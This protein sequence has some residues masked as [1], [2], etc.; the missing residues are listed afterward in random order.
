VLS[1]CCRDTTDTDWNCRRFRWVACQLDYLCELPRDKDRRQALKSL[2]PTLNATYERILGRIETKGSGVQQLVQRCLSFLAVAD[3][4]PTSRELCDAVS[5]DEDMVYLDNDALVDEESIL[6]HCSSL[7]RCRE[8]ELDDTGESERYIE[9]SHFSVL[10]YLEGPSLQEG[11]LRKYRILR[12]D[13]TKAAAVTCLRM[14]LLE[15]MSYHPKATPE[16]FHHIAARCK[17]HPFLRYASLL[18]PGFARNHLKDTTVSMLVSRLF[19]PRKT[20]VFY[21]WCLELYLFSFPEYGLDWRGSTADS[22]KVRATAMAEFSFGMLQKGFGPLHMAATSTLYDVCEQLLESGEDCNATCRMGSP[23]HCAVSPTWFSRPG[24]YEPY[25]TFGSDIRLFASTSPTERNRVVQLLLQRGAIPTNAPKRIDEEGGIPLFQRC[26]DVC[27]QRSNFDMLLSLIES[28]ISLDPSDVPVF[29]ARMARGHHALHPLAME[30]LTQF[31]AR[32]ESIKTAAASKLQP[33]LLSLINS[34][35]PGLISMPS[36]LPQ[37]QFAS[38]RDPYSRAALAAQFNDRSELEDILGDNAFDLNKKI[39]SRGETILHVA[40]RN[41]STSAVDVLVDRGCDQTIPDSRGK[42]PIWVCDHDS[43]LPVLRSLIRC[44]PDI[45]TYQNREGESIWHLAARTNSCQVLD[46]LFDTAASGAETQKNNVGFTPLALALHLGNEAAAAFIVR[47]L[48]DAFTSWTVQMPPMHLIAKSGSLKLAKTAMKAGVA[49]N[50]R[51]TDG[52]SPLHHLQ[53]RAT[54]ELV[55][56]LKLSYP[57]LLQQDLSGRR[58]IES[59]FINSMDTLTQITRVPGGPPLHPPPH[60][61]LEGMLD[62]W[63]AVFDELIPADD[64]AASSD[65][66]TTWERLCLQAG[67][68]LGKAARRPGPLPG[69]LPGLAANG[70]K[71]LLETA[72]LRLFERG[73]ISLHETTRHESAILPLAS[74]LCATFASSDTRLLDIVT[75][76]LNFT[77]YPTQ[78]IESQ[79][80]IKLLHK[81]VRADNVDTVLRLLQMGVNPLAR[82]DD[83]LNALEVACMSEVNSVL[84]ILLNASGAAPLNELNSQE[85]LGLV[86]FISRRDPPD[87][88]GDVAATDALKTLIKAGA[89]P[90]LRTASGHSAVSCHVQSYN[91]D[92]ANLLVDLGADPTVKGPDG[93]DAVVHAVLRGIS[94]FLSH[95]YRLDKEGRLPAEIQWD[96]SLDLV[97]DKWTRGW[98][99]VKMSM[100]G[101]TRWLLSDGV[102]RGCNL[103]HLATVQGHT[104]VME[105]LLE[106]KLTSNIDEQAEGGWT[107]MHF[108]AYHSSAKGVGLLHRYG[109]DLN[110]VAHVV[111]NKKENNGDKIS[112]RPLDIAVGGLAAKALSTL[113]AECLH[114]RP[115]TSVPGQELESDEESSSASSVRSPI[116]L[117]FVRRNM[118]LDPDDRPSAKGL[119]FLPALVMRDIARRLKPPLPAAVPRLYPPPGIARPAWSTSSSSRSASPAPPTSHHMQLLRPGSRYHAKTHDPLFSRLHDAVERD[120]LEECDDVKAAGFSINGPLSCGCA[121]LSRAI[122][123]ERA[124]TAAWLLNQGADTSALPCF[125]HGRPHRRLVGIP[126]LIAASFNARLVGI[127]SRVLTA[128]LDSGRSVFNEN[129]EN[130]I[131]TAAQSQNLHGLRVIIQHIRENK[132]RYRYVALWST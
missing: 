102:F 25:D 24:A 104:S 88:P 118:K 103:L 106:N 131:H 90:N 30:S 9:F 22:D 12:P 82:A 77:Q 4:L 52:S 62:R 21:S 87:H 65:D 89:D 72:I 51:W 1:Q 84:E 86:H 40:V 60:R 63:A 81:T 97:W 107:A 42:L 128:Y 75:M 129:R 98:S 70:L 123:S 99:R 49:H 16:D 68:H 55:R 95:V 69:N 105:F 116:G 47:R 2:P 85:G 58:P 125:R 31:L 15:N 14:L 17:S 6:E 44:K 91:P 93:Y 37:R 112:C 38:I 101:N 36:P 39:N 71:S 28:G 34:G 61:P 130:P 59:F 23:L 19:D 13:A 119:P 67:S 120:D 10:E 64:A 122:T 79:P 117:Y 56:L 35:K 33:A 27:A 74:S 32:L 57:D 29:E 54:A 48:P 127:L 20:G 66:Q 26:L 18:W 41:I 110:A 11:S 5:V 46:S 43:Y 108:A 50:S 78:A 7:V 114:P 53:P 3:A 76:M 111:D 73:L 132:E 45:V 83:G 121:P 115:R 8:S 126:W 100:R 94:S 124:A 109:A 96:Q 113:G 92:T 80:F